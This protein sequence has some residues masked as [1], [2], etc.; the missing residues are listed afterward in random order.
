MYAPKW[1]SQVIKLAQDSLE[2]I[3]AKQK[4]IIEFCKKENNSF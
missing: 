1:S 2:L 4:E 3:F